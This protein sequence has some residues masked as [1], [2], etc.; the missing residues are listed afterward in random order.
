MRRRERNGR[1]LSCFGL[2]DDFAI[3]GG[4]N[5]QWRANLMLL[6][7]NEMRRNMPYGP[8]DSAWGEPLGRDGRHKRPTAK[9]PAPGTPCRASD[10]FDL[11]AAP[12]ACKLSRTT[13][14]HF[15]GA[16]QRGGVGRRLGL[17]HPS[18]KNRDATQ[19]VPGVGHPAVSGAGCSRRPGIG[20]DYWMLGD[21][22]GQAPWISVTDRFPQRLSLRIPGS[23]LADHSAYNTSD[24]S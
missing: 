4:T 6:G 5:L 22:S 23:R 16:V 17:P 12:L 8:L 14:P 24:E 19:R 15:G 11:F 9:R 2:Q 7:I 21:I 10:T 1:L 3:D 18:R 20:G 13:L